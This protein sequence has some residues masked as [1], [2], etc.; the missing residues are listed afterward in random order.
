MVLT[1]VA[2]YYLLSYAVGGSL[3]AGAVIIIVE[4]VGTIG[5]ALYFFSRKTRK[6][7]PAS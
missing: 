5:A 6:E 2:E 1:I 4:F 7:R 3:V